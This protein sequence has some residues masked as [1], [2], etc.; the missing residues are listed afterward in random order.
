MWLHLFGAGL[1]DWAWRGGSQPSIVY[2]AVRP[3]LWLGIPQRRCGDWLLGKF[4]GVGT[5]WPPA[6]DLADGWCR[7][8][9]SGLVPFLVYVF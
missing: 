7:T 8:L 1:V 4:V 9:V 6:D 5:R 3:S 2:A